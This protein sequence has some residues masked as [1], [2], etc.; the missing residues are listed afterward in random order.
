MR[1]GI[2]AA[3]CAAFIATTAS[4]CGTAENLS[5]G[6]KL[7]QAVDRLGEQKAVTLSVGLDGNEQQIWSALKGSDGFTREN[8]ELLAGIDVSLSVSA[9]KPLKDV[10]EGGASLA[11]RIS[12]G[13][14]KDLLEVRGLAGGKTYLRLDLR[15]FM[16]LAGDLGTGKS[17]GDMAQI[18]QFLDAADDLP[19]SYKSVKDALGGKWVSVDPKAFQEFAMSMGE[20]GP[21]GSPLPD[22]PE[23]DAGTQKRVTKALRRA[24]ESNAKFA[25]AGSKDGA[26][27]VKVTVPA[28]KTADAL[29]DA[30][31][32]LADQLPEGV[33]PSDLKDV[34]DKDVTVDVAVKD[35]TLSGISLDLDQF[36]SGDEIHGALPLTV[37]FAPDAAPVAA[38]AGATPLNPQDVMGAMMQFMMGGMDE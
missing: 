24:L 23:L 37:G 3:G 8:A 12:L 35:G 34:P 16:S 19:S 25:D 14:G 31:E 28:G 1:K 9:A 13:R 20:N 32:P 38:P 36:D 2:A 27:I 29:A 11:L 30:L 7:Q 4:A 17:K 18:Q 5:A 26:D 22:T 6:A 21:A 10:K 33:S 15:R